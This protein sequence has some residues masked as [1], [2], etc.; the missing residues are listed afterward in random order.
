MDRVAVGGRLS[1]GVG[2]GGSSGQ[3]VVIAILI[4]G[5]MSR[6]KNLGM[7]DIQSTQETPMTAASH[8]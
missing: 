4:C 3:V 8:H 1:N 2:I 5:R 7:R 6:N